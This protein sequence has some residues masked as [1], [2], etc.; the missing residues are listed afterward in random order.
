MIAAA[1]YLQ[2]WENNSFCVLLQVSLLSSS[3]V[4]LCDTKTKNRQKIGVF[5]NDKKFARQRVGCILEKY[6]L[7]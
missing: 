6:L 2:N 3:L 7:G 5:H 4:F 1:V